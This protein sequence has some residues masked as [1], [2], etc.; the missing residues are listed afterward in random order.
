MVS[1]KPSV[2]RG[3]LADGV[4][5]EI[6]VINDASV[7]KKL[8]LPNT[9][10]RALAIELKRCVPPRSIAAAGEAGVSGL[11]KFVASCFE[12]GKCLSFDDS[13]DGLSQL[14]SCYEEIMCSGEALPDILSQPDL[15]VLRGALM[16]LLVRPV[17]MANLTP[18][19]VKNAC[20]LRNLLSRWTDK[21]MMC[22]NGLVADFNL[23]LAGCTGSNCVGYLMGSSANAKTVAMYLIKYMT[24]DDSKISSSASVFLGWL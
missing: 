5:V 1:T 23:I 7:L 16:K 12:E 21:E 10:N 9:D 3:V 24:K 14:Y 20:L 4:R 2:V 22:R 17:D 13:V 18:P 19:E 6:E 8:R 11:P 15:R